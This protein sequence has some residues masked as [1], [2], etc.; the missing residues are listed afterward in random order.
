MVWGALFGRCLGILVEAVQ[1]NYPTL[2]IFSSC[3]TGQPCVSPGM[4][5]LLGAMS[6]LCG[7]TKMTVSSTVIMFELTGTLNYIVPAMLTLTIAKLVGDGFVKGGFSDI[8]IRFYGYPYL[9]AKDDTIYGVPIHTAM[10]PRPQIS[11]MYSTMRLDQIS[12]LVQ[13]VPYHGFAIVVS[14]TDDRLVG[15]IRLSEFQPLLDS[16]IINIMYL[17]S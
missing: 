9:D 17:L 15:Y 1:R 13:S 5:A 6:A 8:L 14:E 4:Y 10:V 3:V 7:V 11:C 12:D 2:S 16:V